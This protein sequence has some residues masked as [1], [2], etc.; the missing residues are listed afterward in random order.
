MEQEYPGNSY[1]SKKSE[2]VEKPE[3]K[4]TPVVTHDVQVR[5]KNVFQKFT[6]AFI[7]EDFQSVK[8]YVINEYILPGIK[9]MIVGGVDMLLNGK[10]TNRTEKQ[11]AQVSYRNYYDAPSKPKA[12]NYRTDWLDFDNII[13]MTHEEAEDVRIQMLEIQDTC[14]VV[15]VADMFELSKVAGPYT[16]NNYGWSNLTI[17]NMPIVAVR[18]GYMIRMPKAVPID[19][20]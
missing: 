7:A 20:V 11:T 10:A 2:T 19:R 6:E 8:T 17:S 13:Y 9:K 18:N 5:K 14:R 1:L 16:G 4:L 15:R 12:S 3:Q